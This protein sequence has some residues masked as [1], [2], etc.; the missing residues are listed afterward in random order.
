MGF[1]SEVNKTEIDEKYEQ[2]LQVVRDTF[3][4]SNPDRCEKLLKLYTD[5]EERIKEAPASG[6]LTFHS[7]F[8]GG[9]LVHVMN[10][11]QWGKMQMKLYEKM[12][13]WVDFT[14]EEL[15]FSILNHDLNKLGTLEQAHYVPQDSNWHRENRLEVYKPS[16]QGQ[17]WAKMDYVFFLL[18]EY[19]IKMTEN[20]FLAIRLSHGMF[21]D[22]NKDY[23]KQYNWGHW[24]MKNNLYKIVH[25]ADYMA[26]SAEGDVMR[27]KYTR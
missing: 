12:G 7:A 5:Y 25:I 10:V 15:V 4:V 8:P 21:D 20:E 22:S 13:G 27:K 24:P 6:R 16:E 2:L 14:Y 3:E 26:S 11:L 19:G 1:S 23:L 18:Q 17:Y 9:Y